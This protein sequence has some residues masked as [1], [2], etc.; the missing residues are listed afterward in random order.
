NT[1]HWPQKLIMQLIPQ[2]LLVST[3]GKN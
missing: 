2:Q 3:R 1:E